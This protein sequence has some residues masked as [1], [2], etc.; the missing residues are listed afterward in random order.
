MTEKRYKLLTVR[1]VG[2]NKRDLN[3]C[4]SC[5]IK[6]QEI[7]RN[8]T[9]ADNDKIWIERL[10]EHEVKWKDKIITNVEKIINKLVDKDK[11]SEFNSLL[12]L[13]EIKKLKGDK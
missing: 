11:L 1:C 12:I 9:L 3:H 7:E 10:K 6:C 5:V 2:C 13:E 8:Q 4:N